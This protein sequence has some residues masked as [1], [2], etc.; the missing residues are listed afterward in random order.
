MTMTYKVRR[1]R[2]RAGR[3]A[4]VAGG[5]GPRQASGTSTPKVFAMSDIRHLLAFQPDPEAVKFW[6][7]GV[8]GLAL[9]G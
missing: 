8:R 4:V 7:R 2:L 5:A 9:C 3:D 6:L 1:W